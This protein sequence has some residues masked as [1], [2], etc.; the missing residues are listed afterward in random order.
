MEWESSISDMTEIDHHEMPFLVEMRRFRRRRVVPILSAAFLA[1][2]AS[3]H[4]GAQ[5]TP[6][7]P[8]T[9]IRTNADLVVLDVTVS[10]GQQNPVHHLAAT[11]FTVLEN[12]KP[13]TV[14]AFEEHEAGSPAPL[15]PAPR[16]APGA[17]T[18]ESAAPQEGTLNILLFDQLNTPTTAQA[19]VRAQ[20]LQYLKEAPGGTRMAIFS[21]TTELKLL[22]GFTTNPDLLRALV[23]G[24]KGN[25]GASAVMNDP[26]HGGGDQP[27]SDDTY[28]N[29]MRAMLNQAVSPNNPGAAANMAAAMVSLQQFE[30]FQQSLQLQIRVHYTLDALNQLAHALSGLPGRKNLIWFSGS[31]PLSIL[32]EPGLPDPFADESSQESEFRETIDLLS[33]GQVSVYPIDARGGMPPPM[34]DASNAGGKYLDPNAFNKDDT[35]FFNETAGQHDTMREMAE[36]TGG[37]AYL[38]TNGLKDAVE[39][40]IN[41]GSNYYTVAY[42]PTDR[43]WNGK[44]RKIQVKL[45]RRGVT[46]AYRRGYFADDPNA[47]APGSAPQNEGPGAAQSRALRAAMQPGAPEPT[48]LIFVAHVQPS[49]V[50]VEAAPAPG[51]QPGKNVTGPYRRYTITFL[52][53]PSQVSWTPAANGARHLAMEFLTF[54][55]D[56]NGALINMQTNRISGD[57]P[58]EKFPSMMQQKFEFHQQISVPVK[59]EYDLRLG[60]RDDTSDHVGA[61]ELPVTAVAKLPPLAAA[62]TAPA[63]SN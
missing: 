38:N 44:F 49:T 63:G 29:N 24:K 18:N 42:T 34:M 17:F 22:Q 5:S 41:A 56:S 20:V 7:Q 53:D 57:I 45:D 31:F 54:V 37:K 28:T 16:L 11:D 1:A 52:A 27:G 26:T 6:A 39:Q 33:R 43:N 2:V 55:Y 50:D 15:P 48:G 30:S 36:A 32:P 8:Q 58:A 3:S 9:T 40:A 47:P 13:Q 46:L 14:T 51:N 10:D 19:D 21:L 4:T 60:V 61:L 35:D 62:A 25:S 59:G 12:G 23:E